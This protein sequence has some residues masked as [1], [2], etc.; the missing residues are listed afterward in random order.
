MKKFKLSIVGILL[1]CVCS[2]AYAVSV[3]FT[4]SS[5]LVA[6]SQMICKVPCLVTDISIYGDG[7]NAA[8]VILYDSISGATGTVLYKVAL[9][10]GAVAGGTFI[11][12]PVKAALG[13]YMSIS[14]TGA[15]AIIYTTPQ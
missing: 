11:P 1:L 9:P 10:S 3:N 13:V 8:T 7:T 12:I 5:G 15:S 6:T 14:G 4:Y 2:V